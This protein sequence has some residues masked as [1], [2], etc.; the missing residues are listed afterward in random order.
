MSLAGLANSRG[1]MLCSNYSRILDSKGN[2]ILKG[3]IAF[4]GCHH[5]SLTQASKHCNLS[6]C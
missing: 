6:G 5:I 2:N 4:D 3:L 1:D